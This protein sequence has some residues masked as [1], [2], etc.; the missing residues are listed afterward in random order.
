MGF[1]VSLHCHSKKWN[2]RN[3]YE[4]LWECE[5]MTGNEGK[6]YVSFQQKFQS[7][8]ALSTYCDQVS[9]LVDVQCLWA[10][11]PGKP[12][13]FVFAKRTTLIYVRN[14]RAQHLYQ[15]GQTWPN[16][17]QWST[18]LINQ[19]GWTQASQP[20]RMTRWSRCKCHVISARNV[21]SWLA[22]KSKRSWESRAQVLATTWS[23]YHPQLSKQCTKHIQR[24]SI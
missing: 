13:H 5:K 18:S 9:L 12:K 15:S 10:S 1:L 11:G 14:L 7:F 2:E 8:E 21:C 23:T 20:L 22:S 24:C 4:K 6:P 19:L 16:S 17:G 3:M